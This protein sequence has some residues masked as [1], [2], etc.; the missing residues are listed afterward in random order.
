[1]S[2]ADFIVAPRWLI[3]V[4]PSGE[5]LE[6]HAVVVV[7]GRIEALLP[8][9]VAKERY[10]TLECLERPT[11]VLTAG[12]VNTHTH[13]P[14]SLLRGCADDLPL[15]TWLSEHIW[16]LEGRWANR[17]FARDG[18]DLAILEMISSGTTCFQDMYMFPDEVAAV[19]AERGIRACV[20]MIVIEAPTAWAET[21]DEYIDKGLAVHDRYRDHPLI[22]TSFGP[23][24]PYTVSDASLTR[25]LT[26]ANQ[27]DVQVHMHV[28]ET[29]AEIAQAV[30]ASGK[31]PLQRLQELG[32]LT[33]QLNAVHMTQLE[34]AEIAQL[35]EAG[36]HVLHCP[37]S[38]M[39]L[40][41]GSCRVNDLMSAGVNVALGTDGAASNND[42][43][44]LGEMQSAALLAKHIS[45]D[46]RALGAAAALQMATLN[47]ARAMGLH[48]ETGSLEPGKAADM[49]CVDLAAPSTQ[50]VLNPLSALVYSASREQVRDVWVAGRTLYQDGNFA[51]CDAAEILERAHDWGTKILTT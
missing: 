28:H 33:P 29:A 50:P 10:G 15:D 27:L 20:S 51:L 25:I 47:G 42:L 40:A 43:D 4:I 22:Q 13:A 9:A 21:A 37:E 36:V 3:P 19:A 34:D 5:I 23:H 46:A 11:H 12:F 30:T 38:N 32:A 17:E 8:V 26:L 41:S 7:D 2:D 14:M 48:K 31:R 44:M 39:K 1:M 35:A 6:Q 45:G 16:P 24:A 49:I 18:A